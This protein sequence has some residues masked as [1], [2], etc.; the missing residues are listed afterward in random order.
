MRRAYVHPAFCWQWSNCPRRVIDSTVGVYFPKIAPLVDAIS[1]NAHSKKVQTLSHS[2]GFT[3]HFF[4]DVWVMSESNL[5][6]LSQIWVKKRRPKKRVF[7]T[8]P[9]SSLV[10]NAFRTPSSI[11]ILL[12]ILF[13]IK[14][15]L[16]AIDSDC[17]PKVCYLKLKQQDIWAK[18]DNLS[19]VKPL[20][21]CLAEKNSILLTIIH[22]C[23]G[24]PR[25]RPL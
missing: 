5:I 10:S 25:H 23:L 2:R 19:P 20:L 15:T 9:T 13:L 4:S 6:C 11:Q 8:Y 18:S 1:H 21:R 16:L 17:L 24:P 22:P 12:L 3:R 7:T 14:W